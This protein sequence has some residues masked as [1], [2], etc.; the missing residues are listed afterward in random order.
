[1]D[2]NVL[3]SAAITPGGIPARLL[4]FAAYRHFEMLVSDRLLDEL[5][6]VLLRPRFRRYLSVPDAEDFV[7]R[8]LAFTTRVEDVEAAKVGSYTED[9]QDDYLV[10]L[11]VERGADV[12]VS[13]DRHLHEPPEELPV[14]VLRP[15]DF[16]GEL[17]NR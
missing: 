17:A 9:P 6:G 8:R 11:A 12:I 15:A 10:A 14:R 1:M 2:P 16:F 5:H 7:N 4:A 3:V 13:G